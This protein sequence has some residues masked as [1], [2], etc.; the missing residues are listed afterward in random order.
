MATITAN[1]LRRPLIV[2]CLAA[3]LL[4]V[5][6]LGYEAVTAAR[7]QRETVE[8][9]LRDYA[10]LAAEQYARNVGVTFDYE[11]IFPVLGLFDGAESATGPTVDPDV[12]VEGQ[13]S[14]EGSWPSV[15]GEQDLIKRRTFS[16]S[17]H[18]FW[19]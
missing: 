15:V 10:G 8:G 16:C 18:S 13:D 6:A 12:Q 3:A 5:A 9:V 4:M 11:L 7:A 1:N 14:A 17:L 2:G 19:R